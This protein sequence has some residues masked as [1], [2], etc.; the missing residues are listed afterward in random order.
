MLLNPGTHAPLFT[1]PDAFGKKL[2]LTDFF[3]FRL[4]MWFFPKANTSG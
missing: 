4:V 1:L 2:S 3:G